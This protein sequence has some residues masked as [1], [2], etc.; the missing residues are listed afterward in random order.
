MIVRETEQ[1]FVMTTQ[2]DHAQL[3]GAIAERIHPEITLYQ[4]GIDEVE[5]MGPRKM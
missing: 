1:S 4:L 2:H 5:A 3:S